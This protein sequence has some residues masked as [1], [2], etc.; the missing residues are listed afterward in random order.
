MQT[1]IRALAYALNGLRHAFINERNFK[2]EIFCAL[3]TI[4]M[5]FVFKIT[6]AYWLVVVINICL[7][8]TAELFNTAIEKLADVTCKEINPA[9]KII[10]DVAAAAV[11]I[12][13]LSAFICGL[14][15]FIPSLLKLLV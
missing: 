14:I 4:F 13:G 3:I 15:I 1:T 7:V 5:G 12:A 9:I 6:M 2:I 8:L 10:K 11:V